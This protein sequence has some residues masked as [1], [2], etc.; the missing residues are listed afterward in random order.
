LF[1]FILIGKYFKYF[2]W[3]IPQS[4]RQYLV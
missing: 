1:L 2:P 3:K 4:H